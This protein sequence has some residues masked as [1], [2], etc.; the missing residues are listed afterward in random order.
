MWFSPSY[1]W[2]FPEHHCPVLRPA[3]LRRGTE[4]RKIRDSPEAPWLEW[5]PEVLGVGVTDGSGCAP[6]QS[7]RGGGERMKG[8][9]VASLQ[10]R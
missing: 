1:A 10:A 5:V 6:A 2:L 7:G 9:S 8:I 3:I 4:A